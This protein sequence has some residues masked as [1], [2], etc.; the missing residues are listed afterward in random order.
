MARWPTPQ[1]YLYG[2]IDTDSPGYRKI[3]DG[4]S[5]YT[6]AAGYQRLP[7]LL[8]AMETATGETFAQDTD[9][10]I[11][12]GVPGFGNDPTWPDRLGWLL[13]F[14]AE[15]GTQEASKRVSSRHV[16]P[17]AIPLL[18]ASLQPGV[19]R[20]REEELAVDRGRRGH[21]YVW[22]EAEVWAFLLTA[23]WEALEAL[24]LG[25]CVSGQVTVSQWSAEDHQNGT[26][27]AWSTSNTDGYVDGYAVGLERG[28]W[29][30]DAHTYW[31]GRLLLAR[32][33]R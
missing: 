8:D 29:L 22:G 6:A 16:P 26:A 19:D 18:G 1:A 9:G 31:E 33:P 24:R 15:P 7:A 2:W 11:V 10:K 5:T 28:R 17:A 23:H 4:G 30:D 20:R 32:T 13:G 27:Y 3:A 25:W 14:A 21:G 12:V